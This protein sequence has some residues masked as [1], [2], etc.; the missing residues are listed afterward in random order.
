MRAVD[1]G[2]WENMV[3]GRVMLIPNGIP[4]SLKVRIAH[5]SETN[6]VFFIDEK[7]E[8]DQE[9]GLMLFGIPAGLM[10][11]DDSGIEPD[12]LINC[13]T[14]ARVMSVS[15]GHNMHGRH[16]VNVEFIGNLKIEGIEEADLARF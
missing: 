6:A 9:I 1:T 8:V 2:E 13:K 7:L 14:R 12:Q 11:F 5:A 4:A 10:K 16:K 15:E 3:P